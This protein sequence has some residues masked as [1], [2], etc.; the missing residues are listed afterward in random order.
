MEIYNT[1]SIIPQ[2]H[3]GS[4]KLGT[5]KHCIFKLTVLFYSLHLLYTFILCTMRIMD[6]RIDKSIQ[7]YNM[8]VVDFILNESVTPS[9]NIPI[10]A[11]DQIKVKVNVL[12]S[13]KHNC[14]KILYCLS[15]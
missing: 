10:S 3:Q 9:C 13:I 2:Q 8:Y 12:S 7:I 14:A 15:C 4:L 1:V 11:E 6:G 5:H